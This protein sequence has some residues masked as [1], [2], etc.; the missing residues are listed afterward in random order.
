[1][2]EQEYGAGYQYDPDLPD[3]FSGQQYFPESMDREV[4]Y[5]PPDR[6]FEREIRKRLDYWTLLIG[7]KF[8]TKDRKGVNLR[9]RYSINQIEYCLNFVFRRSFPIHRPIEQISRLA[10]P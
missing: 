3:S 4:Y 9:R 2:K 7:P 1:M 10:R 8:S 6:G 5:D